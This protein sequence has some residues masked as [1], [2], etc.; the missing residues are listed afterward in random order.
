MR[1]EVAAELEVD[2]TAPTTLEFQIAVAPHPN[3]EVSESLSFVMHGNLLQPLEISGAHGNRI[4]KLDV[5]VGKLKVDYAATIVGQTDPAPVT[6][7]DLS[8]YLRPSRYAESDKFFGFAATE[9][10]SYID[11]TTL[12]EK[13]SLWVGNRLS[14]VPGSSDPI[15][16]AVD[17]LLSGAGVCRDF[18][19]LV[20][21]LLRAVKVPARVVSVYAPSGRRH[22]LGAEAKPGADRHRTRCRR[23]RLP[24]QPQRRDHTGQTV[25][26]GRRRRRPAQGLDRP[27][28]VDPLKPA[29]L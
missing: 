8:V 24:R 28:S 22:A 7:H 27:A 19:H 9:F 4:H 16:G 26:D 2:I 14:Y 1:R 29:R 3:T 13:V 11:S 10:G 23:H 6:E 17:T 25:G 21:A 15:D 18:A 5:P 12:L 20:V